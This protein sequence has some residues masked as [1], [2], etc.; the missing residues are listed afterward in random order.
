MARKRPQQV[1]HPELI[2]DEVLGVRREYPSKPIVRHVHFHAMFKDPP[3]VR[4]ALIRTWNTGRHLFWLTH[5]AGQADAKVDDKATKRMIGWSYQAGYA[6]IVVGAIY[7]V[8][9][10]TRTAATV[11]HTEITGDLGR[12]HVN[13]HGETNTATLSAANWA[14]KMRCRDA[15]MA[16]GALTNRE[17]EDL[18]TWLAIFREHAYQVRNWLCIGRDKDGWPLSPTSP[19]R[20]PLPDRLA[21]EPWSSPPSFP[22]AARPPS[23]PRQSVGRLKRGQPAGQ[24]PPTASAP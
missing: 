2:A 18:G 13:N 16:T 10:R 11:W 19:T 7:P 23:K 5:H 6:G 4:I 3:L 22:K 8:V 1:A 17:D 9:A 24:E 15:V 21:L 12:G 20:P 14:N